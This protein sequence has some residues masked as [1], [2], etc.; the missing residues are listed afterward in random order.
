MLKECKASH[1]L[2]MIVPL[3]VIVSL[4]SRFSRNSSIVIIEKEDNY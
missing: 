1:G 4:E 3:K 2:I